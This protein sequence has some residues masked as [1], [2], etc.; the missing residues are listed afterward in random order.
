MK[1]TRAT[2]ICSIA[3]ISAIATATFCQPPLPAPKIKAVQGRVLLSAN[4]SDWFPAHEEATMHPGMSIIAPENAMIEVQSGRALQWHLVGPG[5][6]SIGKRSKN[7]SDSSSFD[8]EIS[9]GHLAFALNSA[10]APAT[11]MIKTPFGIVETTNGLFSVVADESS[12][13]VVAVSEGKACVARAEQKKICVEKDKMLLMVSEKNKPPRIEAVDPEI[14]AAWK[15]FDWI[16]VG[17]KPELKIVQPQDG[18][19]SNNSTIY[20]IGSASP[21]ATLTVNNK[22]IAVAADGSFNGNYTLYEGENKLAIQARSKTGKISS[23]TRTV[24]LDTTPPLLSISQ[25]A[26]SF[27]PTAIGTCDNRFC[28]IQIFGITEPGVALRINGVDVSRFIEDD[29]SFLIQD[30]PVKHKERALTVEAVDMHRQRSFDILNIIEPL[31]SDSDGV[32]DAI[33]DCPSD[34]SCN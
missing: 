19:Y 18:M 11:F 22:Q 5:K 30:F 10:D 33:D 34:P 26:G 14:R 9:Q 24:F 32:P 29:G 21:G 20:I 15:K 7:S 12:A 13:L 2:A 8:I 25:P 27:D 31:D 1:M 6:G 28:Y 4:N 16:V 3:I 23:V 17:E